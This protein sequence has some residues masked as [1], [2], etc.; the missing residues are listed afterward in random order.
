MCVLSDTTLTQRIRELI[1]EP[2]LT[3][4][5]PASIDIRIG[6]YLKYEHESTWDLALQGP[7]IL[8]PK[9]FVLVSTYEHL[10]VP[11]DCCMELKLKSTSARLGFD[12]S[13]AFHFDPGWSGIGTMEIQ[14]ENRLQSLTLTYGQRFAQI[15][16]HKL[17]TPVTNPYKGKYQNATSVE[18]AK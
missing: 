4:I 6:K 14:N 2:D 18:A 17:D 5:N 11:L 3:L 15:I 13:Q 12:H 10:L 16:Y 9:E 8:Q 7:Y 1:Q